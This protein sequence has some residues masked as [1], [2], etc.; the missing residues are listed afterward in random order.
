[1][2]TQLVRRAC[3]HETRLNGRAA[4]WHHLTFGELNGGETAGRRA[5]ATDTDVKSLD[6]EVWR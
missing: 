5:G 4:R 1:M 3:F 6:V 2:V